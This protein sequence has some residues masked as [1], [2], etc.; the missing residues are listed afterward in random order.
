MPYLSTMPPKHPSFPQVDILTTV[1][2][3]HLPVQSADGLPSF[4]VYDESGVFYVNHRIDA[5]PSWTV[6]TAD[7]LH[8]SF[9]GVSLIA[10]NIYNWLLELRWPYINNLLD[11]APQPEAY[12]LRETP[13]YF[14]ALRHNPY[15]DTCR[16]GEGQ[17]ENQA[18]PQTAATSTSHQIPSG[19]PS[20]SARPPS[21]IPQLST[22][23]TRHTSK[24]VMKVNLGQQRRPAVPQSTA[25]SGQNQPS[26][27]S[28]NQLPTLAKSNQQQSPTGQLVT[29]GTT[30]WSSNPK[31]GKQG[32]DTVTEV[33]PSLTDWPS[34]LKSTPDV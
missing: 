34:T 21:R 22:P 7:G 30:G 12:E 28:K 9:A 5:L 11:L 2:V 1:S 29:G 20:Q 26:P 27:S 6:L 14:Q 4:E 25:T 16:G 19:P 32:L 18:A 13:S 10:W 31:P 3:F 33:G 17:K 15:S 24:K 8:P 23:P